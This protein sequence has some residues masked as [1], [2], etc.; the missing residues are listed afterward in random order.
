MKKKIIFVVIAVMLAFGTLNMSGCSGENIPVTD[1]SEF[2]FDESTGMITGFIGSSK[3]I[4][5]PQEINGVPVQS[6]GEESFK[7]KE[8]TAVNIS[9][10]VGVIVIYGAAFADCSSLKSVNVSDKTSINHTAFANCSS[11]KSI[12]VSDNNEHFASVDGVLFNKELTS[13]YCYPGGKSD[14]KYTIPDSVDFLAPY[15]FSG[16]TNLEKIKIPDS[17]DAINGSTFSG[18]TKLKDI[19]LPDSFIIISGYDFSGCTA[20]KNIDLPDNILRLKSNSFDGTT[21]VFRCT[22][23]SQTEKTLIHAGYGD[24]IEYY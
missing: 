8:I 3:E 13:I 17:I 22:K 6:I 20:L 9:D 11:L 5:I 21:T 18:C 23:S 2:E 15:A 1:A 16:C 14:K 24:R 10:N 4:N 7:G 19:T 12:K